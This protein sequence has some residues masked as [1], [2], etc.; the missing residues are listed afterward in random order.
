MLPLAEHFHSIQ[1]E[2]TYVGTPMH[3]IRLAG[4]NVGKPSEK[5]A[6]IIPMLPFIN[7]PAFTCKSW[8]GREFFCDTD[9]KRHGLLS[10]DALVVDTW[11]N[12]VCL[13]GGEPLMHL[14]LL[15]SEEFFEKFCHSMHNCTVHIETSGTKPITP[16]IKKL[17]STNYVWLTVAPKFGATEEMLF[18]ANEIKLVVDDDFTDEGLPS[19]ILDHPNVFVSPIN[20]VLTIREDNLQV[21]MKWLRKYPKWRLSC[22]WHKLIGAH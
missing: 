12:H 21:C 19:V 4:C 1:G 8:D 13:T 14:P 22:Q 15:E 2:G 17:Q 10:V 9:F 3:F 6:G 5:N 16:Y 11:E 7:E 18:F 20:N